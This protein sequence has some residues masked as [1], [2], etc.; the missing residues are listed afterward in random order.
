MLFW[1]VELTG[2]LL[3]PFPARVRGDARYTDRQSRQCYD[4]L[5]YVAKLGEKANMATDAS[6]ALWRIVNCYPKA[7]PEKLLK[8][9]EPTSIDDRELHQAIVKQVFLDT[10]NELRLPLSPASG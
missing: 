5:R 2:E 10:L 6:D 3:Q 9:F 1:R 8:I 4:P 7:S